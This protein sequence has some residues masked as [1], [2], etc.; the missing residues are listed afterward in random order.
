MSREAVTHDIYH[1]DGSVGLLYVQGIFLSL[2]YA[3]VTR[4]NP[5]ISLQAKSPL[6][7]LS[8]GKLHLVEQTKKIQHVV[9]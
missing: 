8:K 3:S 6:F 1:S 4:V 5:E 7:S 9:L 2:L